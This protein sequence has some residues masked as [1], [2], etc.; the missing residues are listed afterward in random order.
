MAK[1][2]GNK[3]VLNN[4]EEKIVTKYDKKVQKKQEQERRETKAK[5]ITSIAATVILVII[6]AVAGTAAWMNY[7]KIHNEYIDVDGDKI[8]KI[9]FDFYYSMTKQNILNQELFSGMTYGS[10][11]AS[12]MGYDTSKSDSSQTYGGNSDYT[13]MTILLMQ[14][15]QQ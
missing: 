4:T 15:S 10:Y 2:K 7:D 13:C 12:Y 5:K 11:F 14:H 9:E 8:S 3:A 1:V 6:V